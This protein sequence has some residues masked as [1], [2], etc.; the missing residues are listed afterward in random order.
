L[1]VFAS[2]VLLGVAVGDLDRPASG[3]AGGHFGVGGLR[4]GGDEE[5]V[6]LGSGG[7]ADHDEADHAV[8]ADVVPEHVA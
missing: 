2:E 4:V 3:V 6:G 1:G 8:R 7:V 5:V